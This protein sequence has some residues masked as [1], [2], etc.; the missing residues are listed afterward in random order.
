[1]EEK[2]TIYV[3]KFWCE[4]GFFRYLPKQESWLKG[5]GVRAREDSDRRGRER[6]KTKTKAERG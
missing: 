5:P 2:Q 3:V 4:P 6:D 1:M